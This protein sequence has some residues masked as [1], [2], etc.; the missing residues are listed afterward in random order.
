MS[1]WSSAPERELGRIF[2]LRLRRG[3]PFR[4]L[5][6]RTES[7]SLLRFG[8]PA[9]VPLTSTMI[10]SSVVGVTVGAPL[11]LLCYSA[12]FVRNVWATV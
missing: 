3:M 1:P 9:L 8:G 10:V 7:T 5:G 12:L 6:L 11:L 4:S 2:C